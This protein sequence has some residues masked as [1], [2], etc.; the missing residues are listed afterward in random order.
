[1]VAPRGCRKPD[2][3]MKATTRFLLGVVSSALFAVG[4]ARIANQ[5]DP[6]TLSLP[7]VNESIDGSAPHTTSECYALQPLS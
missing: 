6:M 3:V 4:F 5:L 2:R 1:M 7:G